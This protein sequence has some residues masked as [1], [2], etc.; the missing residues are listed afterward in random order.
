M[1]L[2]KPFLTR[3]QFAQI[4]SNWLTHWWT[5]LL[6]SFFFSRKKHHKPLLQ[7]WLR[8]LSK[9]VFSFSSCICIIEPHHVGNRCVISNHQEFTK[10]CWSNPR[11]TWCKKQMYNHKPN[12]GKSRTDCDS[13]IDLRPCV[14]MEVDSAV[15]DEYR[16]SKTNQTP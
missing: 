8:H 3:L 7:F 13:T 16:S 15:R 14:I 12:Y 4:N 5:H 11:E 9:T 6:Q 10:C 2:Y 1:E